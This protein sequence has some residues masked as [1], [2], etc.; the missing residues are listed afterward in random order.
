VAVVAVVAEAAASAVADV[1]ATA[2]GLRI[3]IPQLINSHD[4]WLSDTFPTEP[5]NTRAVGAMHCWSKKLQ[6]Y[7][8]S[9]IHV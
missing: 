4:A 1:V 9:S 3:S 2:T 8:F 5:E 6:N 7:F